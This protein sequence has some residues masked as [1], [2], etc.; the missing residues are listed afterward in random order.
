MAKSDTHSR[1]N[2]FSLGLG[3]KSQSSH[4]RARDK[5]NE[6]NS[7]DWYIPYH[8][9]YEKPKTSPVLGPR[10]SWGDLVYPDIILGDNDLNSRYLD[11]D[12]DS[13][14]STAS[15]R[16]IRVVSGISNYTASSGA[17]D[18]S[19]SNAGV[20]RRPTT[21]RANVQ[22][23]ISSYY[24]AM[25]AAAGGVG[26]SPVPPQRLA[27]SGS[28][29]SG[30]NRVTLAN[31][32]SFSGSSKN[33]GTPS[34]NTNPGRGPDTHSS[35]PKYLRS[36]LGSN[37]S[38]RK[39]DHTKAHNRRENAPE[40]HPILPAV[41]A[42][43][44]YYD[45]YYS[46]LL[47]TPKG[48][49]QFATPFPHADTPIASSSR[50]Q[51]SGRNAADAHSHAFTSPGHQLVAHPYAHVLPT[52]IHPNRPATAPS[53]AVRQ[54]SQDPG[55]SHQG[56]KEANNPSTTR[57]ARPFA[58]PSPAEIHQPQDPGP[59]NHHR[60]RMVPPG[61][62]PSHSPTMSRPG[63]AN[64]PRQLKN[65][66]SSPDLRSA[67]R[68]ANPPPSI[69]PKSKSSAGKDRWLSIE[70]WCDAIVFPRPRFYLN[71]PGE[72]EKRPL[73]IS[74][75]GSPIA[76]TSAYHEEHGE[77]KSYG[78]NTMP[79]LQS[80]V[81]L[82]SRSQTDLHSPTADAGSS[83]RPL[84]TRRRGATLPN[85]AVWHSPTA[86]GPPISNGAP[87]DPTR[88]IPDALPSPVP[89]LTKYVFLFP[90]SCNPLTTML[91]QSPGGR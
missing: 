10:D 14:H 62:H 77:Q 84:I 35:Q 9:P 61:L 54:Q 40:T 82:H 36:M 87:A 60:Q 22:S 37:S 80:R 76:S 78:K 79:V 49:D 59:S 34:S 38:E 5:Q 44:E 57:A 67:S 55:P 83:S 43:E 13:V 91:Y 23:H 24:S 4:R 51:I 50:L 81:L 31:F 8:G 53:A 33:I 52:P 70:T 56:Q 89:S 32:F 7:E 42:D 72:T 6:E 75:P 26:E 45:S 74:P 16:R 11:H 65:S 18:P 41:T 3:L 48:D 64:R 63:T 28:S 85:G 12:G 90:I 66:I 20:T 15:D 21:A 19:R 17:I 68:A 88:P 46:T 39:R 73:I 27:P 58:A 1:P 47:N 29:A 2:R 69:P 25:D 71:K 30:V 86:E